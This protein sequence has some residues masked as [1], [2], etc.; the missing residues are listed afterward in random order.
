MGAVALKTIFNYVNTREFEIT[1]DKS[2]YSG[3]H[4]QRTEK[5]PV[6]ILMDENLNEVISD[7]VNEGGD[8]VYW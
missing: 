8:I 2:D 6:D 4:V 5:I 1:Y 3:E 7:F